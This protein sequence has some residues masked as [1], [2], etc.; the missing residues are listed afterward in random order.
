M[1]SEDNILI[2]D[3]FSG[4][5]FC[6]QLFS[7]ETAVYLANISNRHLV[8][9]VR[10]PLSHCGRVNWEYGFFPDFFPQL[11]VTVS[12]GIT[13][14]RGKTGSDFVAANNM[15]DAVGVASDN[16]LSRV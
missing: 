3:L 16:W 2:F 7:L 1:D 4:V 6:N 10:F 13:V 14:I 5:G 12:K 11:D 9:C 8:L 15:S